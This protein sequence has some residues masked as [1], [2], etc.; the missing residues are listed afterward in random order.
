MGVEARKQAEL[1]RAG[2]EGGMNGRDRGQ[3]GQSALQFNLF[4]WPFC[5]SASAWFMI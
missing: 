2:S 5:P 1:K 3:A 4:M